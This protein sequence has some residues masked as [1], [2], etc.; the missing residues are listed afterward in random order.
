M[1]LP[2][3]PGKYAENQGFYCRAVT[4]NIETLKDLSG[5]KAILHIPGS[6]HFVLLDHI[7][8]KYVW[9]IDLTK[10][11][12]Y[13]RVDINF[14]DMDW[15]EGTALLIS[16]QPISLQTETVEIPDN[17]L[18]G[19]IGGT[20]YSCTYL[21]QD[22]KIIHCIFNGQTCMGNYQLIFPRYG[23][24]LSESGSCTEEFMI[25]KVVWPCIDH[26]TIP[27]T[28]ALDS[29]HQQYFYILACD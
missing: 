11:K 8:Q 22:I 10:D 15:M 12:F 2:L 17:Q 27:Y 20:G 1:P 29:G 28:C 14:F 6:N 24:E 18:M 3:F 13:Y 4:T 9:I 5:C 25:E 21:I 16:N 23:C 26:P 19:Y 7:D